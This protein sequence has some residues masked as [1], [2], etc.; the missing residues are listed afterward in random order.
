[1]L[2][3]WHKLGRG[4]SKKGEKVE[5]ESAGGTG[6]NGEEERRLNDLQDDVGGRQTH[7]ENAGAGLQGQES[8]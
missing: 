7:H 1:M 3:R 4:T 5:R 8:E 6:E 2:H